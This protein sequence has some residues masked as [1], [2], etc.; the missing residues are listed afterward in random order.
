MV[1][2]FHAKIELEGVNPYV[3]VSAEQAA[4]LKPSWRKP[5]PVKVQVDG[6]P[7]P[8]WRINMMPAGGGAFRLYLHAQVRKV[9]GTGVGDNVE[10]TIA[11]DDDYRSGPADPMPSWFAEQL[12]RNP[13][14]QS[15]WET[16]TPSIQKEILRYFGR[17]KSIET[18]QQNVR[19]AIHV[20]VG[21][22]GRFLA[23]SWAQGRPLNGR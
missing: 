3:W 15:S 8:A 17:L 11:F 6:N 5:M 12:Q 4:S 23:R 7:D 22:E 10:V 21:G 19:K 16:L 18:Q 20:L 1:L 14:A 2:Q 9:S 13:P